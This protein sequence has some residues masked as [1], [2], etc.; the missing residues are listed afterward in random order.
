MV[1][2]RGVKIEN[3]ETGTSYDFSKC[4]DP[5]LRILYNQLGELKERIKVKEEFLKNI[6][7]EGLEVHIG[8][9]NLQKV[10]PPI[11]TSKSSYKITFPK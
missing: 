7:V 5:E 9:G 8:E 1:T 11:K 6:P 10:F 4:D 3:A 2:A